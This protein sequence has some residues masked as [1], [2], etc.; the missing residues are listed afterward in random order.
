MVLSTLQFL[1]HS[2]ERHPPSLAPR[3]LCRYSRVSLFRFPRLSRL[4]FPR[5]R[6]LDRLLPPVL[7]SSR[8]PRSAH[9]LRPLVLRPSHLRPFC[10]PS[11]RVP[12]VCWPTVVLS[13]TP[14]LREGCVPVVCRPTW[15]PTPFPFV[16]FPVRCLMD[17]FVISR[18]DS[19]H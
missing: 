6:A 2:P 11:S 18:L 14:A 12:R 9:R 3:L 19:L 15:F 13:N 4:A 7:P 17:R 1:P 8:H 5:I 10:S 16:L